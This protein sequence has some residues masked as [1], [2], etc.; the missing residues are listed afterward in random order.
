PDQALHRRAAGLQLA[1]RLRV[2][3]VQPSLGHL[4]EP[5][6]AG[7]ERLRR[8]R[9]EP[10]GEL[11]LDQ[12]GPLA[13]GARPFLRRARPR[14]QAGGGARLPAA[15]EEK[16]EHGA[17]DD[18]DQHREQRDDAHVSI[19]AAGCDT[20]RR[21]HGP[22]G[23]ASPIRLAR[24]SLSIG[25]VGL[26]NVGKSTLFNALT[27]ASALASNYPFATIEPNVGIVGIPDPRLTVLARLFGSA[28]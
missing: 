2:G 28:R 24:V 7:V 8:Q 22:N 19:V 20:H 25:I 18:A 17:D 6:G 4:Q 15:G 26:P 1:G 3:G 27:R 21:P 13:G 16:T 9:L 11:A 23:S 5:P 12:G 14:G 10:L